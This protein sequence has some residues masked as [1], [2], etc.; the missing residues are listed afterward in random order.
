MK[1]QIGLALVT[2]Q[3]IKYLGKYYSCERAIRER[4]FEL[5]HIYGGWA[6]QVSYFPNDTDEIFL[7]LD[8]EPE[9]CR[10]ITPQDYEGSKLERYF[11]SIQLLKMEWKT[12]QKKRK[13]RNPKTLQ[14]L[15][16][17]KNIITEV[18]TEVE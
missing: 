16:L 18:E 8:S 9:Q 6:I 13:K 11:L 1:E 15:E 2:A 10:V 17:N 12:V 3:G 5:A 14:K 4:W 7:Q